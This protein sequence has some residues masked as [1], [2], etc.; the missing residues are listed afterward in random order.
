MN[1]LFDAYRAAHEQ[2]FIPI[3]CM[4]DFDSRRQV[5]ACLEAGCKV[6][7]YT[8]RKPDAREMIPWIRK[9]YPD[10]YLL[11]G[12]VIDDESIVKHMHRKNPGL[13]TIAE[14]ADIGVDGF[15]SMIGW[16]EESIRKYAPTHMVCPTAMTVREALLQTAAGAHFQKLAGND[17]GLVKRCR[18]AAAF[19]YCP[20]LVTGGQTVEAMPDTF[21]A[22]AAMVATGFDLSLKGCDKDVSTSDIAT[23]IQKYLNAAQQAQSTAFPKLETVKDAPRDQWLTALPHWHPFDA[24]T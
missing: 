8:L 21:N 24:Q 13:M 11:V 9:N 22:G 10:V 14:I 17:I 3:F 16:T 20:I 18:G 6:V 15:V 5:E 23:V 4:D 2:A 7:E 12:S 1:R 19:D